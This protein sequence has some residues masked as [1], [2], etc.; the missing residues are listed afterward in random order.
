MKYALFFALVFAAL[1]VPMYV[2]T[3][4][5]NKKAIKLGKTAVIPALV[6]TLAVVAVLI[7]NLNFNGKII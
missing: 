6:A 2:S 7:F 1:Y 4:R 5:Q 3:R